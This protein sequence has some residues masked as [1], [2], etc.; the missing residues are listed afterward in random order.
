MRCP[1]LKVSL[2]VASLLAA[3]SLAAGQ[4]LDMWVAPDQLPP[5]LAPY[6]LKDRRAE[7]ALT[8]GSRLA[9]EIIRVQPRVLT[10]RSSQRGQPRQSEIDYDRISAIQ[11]RSQPSEAW[12]S[13]GRTIGVAGTLT[14]GTEVA[15]RTRSPRAALYGL[16]WGPAVGRVA[17][18]AAARRHRKRVVIHIQ[19]P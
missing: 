2:I 15:F 11:L 16:F 10:L 3:Q 19:D 6:L 18:E 9:G 17:G 5:V 12:A 14:L 7:I 1:T 8:N 4:N 13:V